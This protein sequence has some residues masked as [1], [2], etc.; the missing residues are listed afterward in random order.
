MGSIELVAVRHPHDA[1]DLGNE[2]APQV[3]RARHGQRCLQLTQAAQSERCGPPDQDEVSKAPRALRERTV[4][5]PP[6]IGVGGVTDDLVRWP[7]SSTGNEARMPQGTQLARRSRGGGAPRHSWRVA[8]R[9]A[10]CR[11]PGARR[12]RRS[13]RSG[14]A[15]HEGWAL[16][17]ATGAPSRSS[18]VKAASSAAMPR[19]MFLHGRRQRRADA[20]R[21]RWRCRQRHAVPLARAATNCDGEKPGVPPG[22]R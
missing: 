2:V 16:T 17:T 22:T 13:P 1:P 7:G 4:E 10:R 14:V 20:Q 21:V 19:S 8:Q 18:A 5:R 12:C 9:R 11:A 6:R 3:S 15:V